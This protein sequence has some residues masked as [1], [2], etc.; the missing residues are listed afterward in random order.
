MYI[1]VEIIDY[2]LWRIL[3]IQ[4]PWS[5]A[6]PTSKHPWEVMAAFPW[7][8]WCQHLQG[9]DEDVEGMGNGHSHFSS[10]KETGI[11]RWR[12]WGEWF[13]HFEGID[14]DVKGMGN[15]HSH[16]SSFKETG[17]HT[18]KQTRKKSYFEDAFTIQNRPEKSV[19]ENL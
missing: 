19:S 1:V 10:F 13:R 3:N 16:F 4:S 5:S 18:L 2:T 11:H 12:S 8:E 6:H 9:I 7:G 17:I 15:G 14:E